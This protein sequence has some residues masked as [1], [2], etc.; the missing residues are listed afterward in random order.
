M[1]PRSAP[2]AGGRHCCRRRSAPGHRPAGRCGW[3]GSDSFHSKL[4]LAKPRLESGR[5]TLAAIVIALPSP[6]KWDPHLPSIGGTV[7]VILEDEVHDPGDGVGPV[8]GRCAV[9]EHLE[10]IQGD[11]GYGRQ[12]GP[13]RTA[14]DPRAEQCDYRARDDGACRLPEPAWHPAAVI[15]GS[16]GRMNVAAS[17]IGSWATLYEGTSA[18]TNSSMSVLPWA[19]KSSPPIT[20]TG[21]GESEADRP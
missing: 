5:P 1:R 20:S 10:S 18:A 21:T 4:K 6:S 16:P 3:W 11:G 15:A 8:L 7:G 12:V 14:G 9:A 13:L 2:R 17:L 19:R